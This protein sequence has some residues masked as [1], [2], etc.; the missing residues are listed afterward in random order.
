MRATMRTIL[1]LTVLLQLARAQDAPPA[2]PA[3]PPVLENSGKPMV[4]PFECTTEDIQWAGLTCTQDDPCPV[5]LELTAAASAGDRFYAAG[6]IHSSSVTLYSI[7]LG[8]DDAGRTWRE[9]HPRIRA[10]GLDWLQFTDSSS[11]WAAGQLLFPLPQ[12]PFVLRTTDGG[13]TWSEQ[14]VFNENAENHFGSVQLFH[15]TSP[16]AGALVVDRGEGSDTERYALFESSN[17]GETWSIKEEGGKPLRL[18][19]SPPPA[20][21]RV[22]AD[23]PT[24][25][26]HLE[27]RLG[28]RWISR[29]SFAVKLGACKPSEPLR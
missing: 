20:E 23:G 26:F 28:D 2:A 24:S 10:A 29:A 19:S 4:V 7:L 22:R 18:K 17:G 8:S 12:E 1:A 6:N 9:T 3:A 11:G 15:F 21:W 27:R 25:S 14:I 16:T 5:Y 13:K